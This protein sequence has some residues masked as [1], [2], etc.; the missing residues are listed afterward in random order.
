MSAT[1]KNIDI[2]IKLVDQTKSSAASVK[3]GM[4]DIKNSATNL[5]SEVKT[6]QATV[7]AF[8]TNIKSKFDESKV[9]LT[10][11]G[12]AMGVVGGAIVAPFALAGKQAAE[13]EST[14]SAVKAISGATATE[15][16]ALEK[17]A[18]KMGRETRYTAAEAGDAL[19]YMSVAGLEASQSLA[20]LPSVLQLAVAG[21]LDLGT[22]A[23]IATNIMTAYGFAA[24]DLVMIN[25]RMVTAF[26]NTNSTLGE[27]GEGF[28]YVGP[29][30][31]GMGADFDDL[32]S[33]LGLLH[34]AGIKASMA[35]TALRGTLEALYNPTADEAKLLED[36]SKRI[37]G[38]GL[39]IKKSNGE[40]VGF[41]SV[42]RQ[43]EKAGIT[44]AESLRL[45]G[46]RAGQGV[47]A[48]MEQGSEAIGDMNNK[49]KESDGTAARIA[50]TMDDNMV[51]A[52]KRLMSAISGI[53]I[54]IGNN[55]IP[56][57]SVLADSVAS[58]INQLTIF[59][60]FLG[61]FATVIEVVIV[62]FG[63]MIAILGAT[64]LAYNTLYS[65]IAGAIK[66]LIAAATQAGITSFSMAGLGKAFLAAGI[67]MKAFFVGLGPLGWAILAISAAVAGL[68][69]YLGFQ[70]SNAEKSTES[71]KALSE[72]LKASINVYDRYQ[73]KIKSTT[74]FT[75]QSR[76]ENIKLKEELKKLAQQ[77][78]VSPEFIK[79][80]QDAFDSIDR[81]TGSIK[82]NGKALEV[83][84]AQMKSE[85]LTTLAIQIK[86]IGEQLTSVSNEARWW[87]KISGSAEYMRKTY[88]Q[89]SNEVSN[90][91][92]QFGV[93]TEKQEETKKK[94]AELEIAA[95]K[96][97]EA[98]VAAGKVDLSE[99]VL[100]TS[101]LMGFTEELKG[102][103]YNATLAADAVRAQYA[104]LVIA[105]K[106]AVTT[107]AE[108]QAI[109][110]AKSN[111][112][113]INLYK[114][115][116]SSINDSAKERTLAI[117][118]ESAIL[119]S[120]DELSELEKQRIIGV[121]SDKI[122][123]IDQ[124]KYAKLQANAD[125][126]LTA[127]RAEGG[128]EKKIAEAAKTIINISN[129]RTELE[130]QNIQLVAT[131]RRTLSDEEIKEAENNFN[132]QVAWAKA[133]SE[134]ATS[135]LEDEY[136]RK[137]IST[138]SY[139]KEKEKLITQSQNDEIEALKETASFKTTEAEKNNV[140]AGIDVLRI[141][142]G[143]QLRDL[144]QEMAEIKKAQNDEEQ[145]ALNELSNLRLS[146][147]A[148]DPETSSLEKLKATQALEEEALIE[149]YARRLEIMKLAGIDKDLIRATELEMD[150]KIL[151]EQQKNQ[152]KYYNAIAVL[153]SSS[154]RQ[155][156][157]TFMAVYEATGKKHKELFYIAKAAAIAQATINT[158]LGATKAYSDPGGY[159]GMAM[160][161]M[162]VVQGM[163]NVSLIASQSMADGGWV[164]GHSPNDRA[165]NVPVNLTAKEY[166]MPVAVGR[167][168]GDRIMNAMRLGMFPTD[169][170][171]NA[172]NT[173][174]S[175]VPRAM[176]SFRLAEGGPVPSGVS[177]VAA[178]EVRIINLVDPSIFEKYTSEEKGQQAII[179][180]I[181]ERAYEVKQILSQQ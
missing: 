168:Y 124:D 173:A 11:L 143:I 34:N 94:F 161:A 24:S 58:L 2:I 68:V 99:S 150:K 14:M 83:W 132:R 180:V 181:S 138:D 118:K 65:P 166:V 170:L 75:E 60:D 176:P 144:S 163:A 19:K 109:E 40:F 179:N 74:A 151:L 149:S 137:K 141:Q 18:L 116:T 38:A 162:I 136:K 16:A 169:M 177:G 165:D 59:H 119:L 73:E 42:I 55:F 48:L 84:Y 45:F 117:Q 81:G 12:T 157:D 158:Y 154:A 96:T 29:I 100:D 89:L 22:S 76:I 61:P 49:M 78:G 155:V 91:G 102:L 139:Y 95:R 107:I 110:Q 3:K 93:L 30:A 4:E 160:A 164:G 54:S 56:V 25:D 140:L 148:E 175:F 97:V 92:D 130:I 86:G 125:T 10:G 51:G 77:E 21:N 41:E 174:G 79:N 80:A 87:D 106:K 135:I 52:Y 62:A 70:N 178:Q 46:L 90:Y 26:T 71:T 27:L 156:E 23:D 105:N 101:N 28:K 85:A 17:A 31:K 131:T 15:F 67:G 159:L 142:H 112:E 104:K 103:G 72:S 63:S 35:G 43:L 57:L 134:E 147:A 145:N 5:G 111:Q 113:I 33:T 6:L 1:E 69:T 37:G 88:Q 53:A 108:D 66:L 9:S 20:S 172:L 133:R 98:M 153:A 44:A 152:E 13:F 82:D 167:K 129:K 120:N 32:V 47:A 114:D 115:T 121:S 128:D 127:L 126:Y 146:L 171:N 64:V 7:Q 36:I 8:F 123:K 39:Q 122:L 50:K